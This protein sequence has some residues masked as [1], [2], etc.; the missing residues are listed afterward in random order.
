MVVRLSALRTG[1]LY[2]QEMFLVLISVRGWVDPKA[3]VRSEGLCQWKIPITPPGIE[4]VT[5]RFVA[6][7]LNHWLQ[8]KHL[9]SK[10]MQY[11]L[12]F[13]LLMFVNLRVFR[14]STLYFWI[15]GTREDGQAALTI[16]TVYRTVLIRFLCLCPSGFVVLPVHLK[17]ISQG[18]LNKS[19]CKCAVF[20]WS[21][22][23]GRGLQ[24][25]LFT[26]WNVSWLKCIS[27]MRSASRTQ[28]KITSRPLRTQM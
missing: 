26:C 21:M 4:P 10:Y 19:C 23:L 20:D 18:F 5:F 12:F 11:I 15:F 17:P 1:R 16:Q 22:W 27:A 6:Q 25:D 9:N 7:N 14:F 13:F 24:A 8:I 3:I 2:P 28:S